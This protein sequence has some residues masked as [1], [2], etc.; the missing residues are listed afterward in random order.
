MYQLLL[1]GGLSAFNHST[2]QYNPEDSSEQRNI[3]FVFRT[4][5]ILVQSPETCFTDRFVSV[6]FVPSTEILE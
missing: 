3:C 5:S 4:P 1:Y 6:S 2:R